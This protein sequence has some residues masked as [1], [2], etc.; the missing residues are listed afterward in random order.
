MRFF[1]LFFYCLTVSGPLSLSLYV[2]ILH[3]SLLLISWKYLETQ[4]H[5]HTHEHKRRAQDLQDVKLSAFHD[6]SHQLTCFFATFWFFSPFF[7]FVLFLLMSKKFNSLRLNV[8]T[9]ANDCLFLF[10]STFFIYTFCVARSFIVL[11]LSEK[12]CAWVF[13]NKG[14]FLLFCCFCHSCLKSLLYF[15]LFVRL[16]TYPHL[17]TYRCRAYPFFY[18]FHSVNWQC[19][20]GFRLD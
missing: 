17:H 7:P 15:C 18:S 11:D 5:T 2:C 10:L 9:N 12:I 3:F 14:W 16:Y 4:T 1:L 19:A 6:S 8:V 20:C 13:R